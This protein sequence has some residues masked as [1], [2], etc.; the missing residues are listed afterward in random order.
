MFLV[1]ICG[2]SLISS[3]CSSGLLRTGGFAYFNV[4]NRRELGVLSVC[5]TIKLW[6][7]SSESSSS[8]ETVTGVFRFFLFC[9]C[10]WVNCILGRS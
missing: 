5:I 2:I 4:I 1:Q 3:Q 7:D 8:K 9:F 10:N 6:D